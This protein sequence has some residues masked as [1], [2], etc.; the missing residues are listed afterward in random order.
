MEE[1][2]IDIA[3]NATKAYKEYTGEDP[4]IR[5]VMFQ[6]ELYPAL[7][8]PIRE[9][10]LFAG[11][12][13]EYYGE[14]L[15]VDFNSKSAT[16]IGY[17]M[18]PATL[19]ALMQEYPH[20]KAELEELF[21]FWK[22]ESTF[23]KILNESPKEI[24]DYFFPA[25]VGLDEN[26]YLRKTNKKAKKLG[27]GFISGSFDSRIAGLS[28]NYDKL[29]RLGVPGLLDEIRKCKAENP[30]RDDFYRAC[31]I[32]I[33]TLIECLKF[34]ADQAYIL[35]EKQTDKAKKEKFCEMAAAL[36]K[37]CT[38][39]PESLKEAMQ[40]MLIYAVLMRADSYG[41][42]DVY[43]GDFLENDLKCG[44]LTE[45]DAVQLIIGLYDL[46]TSFGSEFDTRIV[47]GGLGR[48]N[49]KSADKFA[50]LATE[51][52]ERRHKIKPVLTLRH[53]KKQNPALL[54]KAV[55]SISKGSIYPTLYNDDA[56]VPGCMKAMDIPY[57]DAVKYFPL[58]CGEIL[59][60]YTSTGS[61]N[62][63]MRFLK[64]LEAALHDGHDGAD[65]NVIGISTGPVEEFTDYEKLENAYFRQVRAAL[66][67][68]IN[69]HIWNKK[70]A[71]RETAFVLQ[72]ILFDNCLERG[73][74]IFGGGIKYFGANI[75]GFGI[76]NT[77]NS[78]A[79][80]KKLVYEEKRLTLR[81]LV[82]ILDSDFEGY[83][84]EKNLM[85]A[86]PKYGNN[87]N[88]VDE[89]KTRIE[90][91][92]NDT[93]H[94]IG[95]KSEL[96]YYTI[97]NVNPGGI[98][99]G[100][101]IAASADGRVCGET[102]AVGNSSVPGT[103]K[104]GITAMLLSCAKVD[105][106]NGGVVTNVNISKETI[107]SNPEKFA[108]LIKAY[109][110]AGGLQLNINCFSKGDLEKALAHPEEYQN[111]IVRVSGFSARFIDLDK[112]TQKHI[113]ERTLF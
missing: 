67:K 70:T 77:A 31:E 11:R 107:S 105:P 35:S 33:E 21:E 104:N 93:A 83:E 23:V 43:F 91:Y 48:R 103:D 56:Y 32:S 76:T 16:Q 55:E 19:K 6:K 12:I 24:H 26:G 109:F 37:L 54:E 106:C 108:E 110:N 7:L 53:H 86:A 8:L 14:F 50:L 40:L 96:S 17:K 81:R 112:V 66:E 82:D 2:Y 38:E 89:I 102:M 90:K 47:I 42:M 15:P 84:E 60:D 57:D 39:K 10:D 34:Y 99:I 36:T 101:S 28:A 85:L 22:K 25:N 51:A 4:A 63:T 78:L 94:E 18:C 71:A 49:E 74:S 95:R 58:G 13:A 9:E 111:L 92:A 59:L 44:R 87:I 3:I 29:L 73:E 64:A 62:S 52:V 27:S 97:A 65:G 41:R 98:K 75:E 45:E 113:M 1:K 61:P 100:P 80:I 69:I 68:D 46:L 30:G 5:E 88:Y 72:S 79:A 20:R